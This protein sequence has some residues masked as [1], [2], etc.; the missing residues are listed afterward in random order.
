MVG[1]GVGAG[2][3]SSSGISNADNTATFVREPSGDVQ[4]A[5]SVYI[6]DPNSP[7]V[8]DFNGTLGSDV[9]NT[10]P[11][12][13]N[14]AVRS[15]LYQVCPSGTI[16]PITHSTGPLAYYVGYFQFNPDGT[17][18]FTRGTTNSVVTIPPPQ[19]VSINR[20]ANVSTISF[21]TTNGATYSL[22]YTNAAG[23]GTPVAGW[24][25]TGSVA[26]DGTTKS[27]SDTT[28]DGVR[29]YR[30]GAR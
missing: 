1:A 21:T 9:D 8:A 6:A 17:M 24:P 18:T 30:V 5:L 16:D 29:F 23:L 20:T 4:H 26:G 11:A 15:D 2:Y 25:S 22:Y 13:F 19:I 28:T 10:T 12:S 7:N 27:L 14:S 3:I